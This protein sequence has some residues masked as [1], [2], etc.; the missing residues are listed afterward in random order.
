MPIKFCFQRINW[1]CIFTVF[2]IAYWKSL[3]SFAPH[4]THYIRHV[5]LLFLSLQ[6]FLPY[7]ALRSFSIPLQLYISPGILQ[8][9]PS[10]TITNDGLEQ[11]FQF[12]LYP[13]TLIEQISNSYQNYTNLTSTWCL[14]IN[15]FKFSKVI[16]DSPFDRNTISSGPAL[17]PV[18]MKKNCPGYTR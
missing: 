1:S 6:F 12:D 2:H 9:G 18:Y 17:G 16:K 14:L 4:S 11:L 15:P 5:C 7:P 3:Q 8:I 13:Q 10:E